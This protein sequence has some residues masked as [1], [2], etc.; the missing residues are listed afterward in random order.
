MPLNVD[1]FLRKKKRVGDDLKLAV[2]IQNR[3]ALKAKKKNEEK[4]ANYV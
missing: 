1:C 2:G 3:C 4:N